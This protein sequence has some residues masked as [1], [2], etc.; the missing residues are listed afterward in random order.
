MSKMTSNSIL[1]EIRRLHDTGQNGILRLS[2]SAGERVEVFFR[3]GMI[4]AVSSNIAAYRLGN[5]LLKSGHT[6]KRDLDS[7]QSEAR[8]EKILLGEVL[9]RRQILGPIELGTMVRH[10][11]I[12]LIEYVLN[13]DFAIDSFTVLFR[14]HYVPARIS[15]PQLLLE[16][17]RSRDPLFEVP[18]GTSIALSDMAGLAAYPWN[19]HELSVLSELQSPNTFEGLLSTTRMDQPALKKILGVLATVGVIEVVTSPACSEPGNA[20]T[21]ALVAN[22]DFAFEHLIPVVTNPVLNEKL[23][24]ARNESSFASE[25]FRTL[26]VCIR[27]AGATAPFKVLAVSSPEPQD[28]KSMIS[29][30]LAF[31]FAM[32]P[33][34]RTI[35]VDCDFR[36]ST[37]QKYLGVPLE[38]GFLQY[39]TEG[40]LSPYCFVRRIDNLYFLTTGGNVQNPI[41]ILS[42]QKMKQLIER[43]RRDFDTVILDSPP[44]TPIADARIV[45]GLSDGSIMVLRRGRTSYANTDRAFKSA[46]RNKLLGVVFNDVQPMLFNTY[47]NFDYY[48]KNPYVYANVQ[49]SPKKYLKS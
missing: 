24:V 23:T 17:C 3:D 34:E 27:Q 47:H 35:I 28:G 16:T 32:D 25:Q 43:L 33:G 38:P 22:S 48:G 15:F 5:Y 13:G 42:M 18:P 8:R 11:G 9:V 49:K 40:N 44:Y 26:K 45:T 30:N 4:D 37:L 31:S 21:T 41:E 29:T 10:Q 6:E 20:Q 2:S 46:D 1:E 7:A 39:L 14:S 19:P 12:D 36:N